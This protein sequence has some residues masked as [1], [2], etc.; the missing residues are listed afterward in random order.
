MKRT[1]FGVIAMAGVSMLGVAC[2]RPG[3]HAAGTGY[4]AGIPRQAF[5]LRGEPRWNAGSKLGFP[6]S[7]DPPEANPLTWNRAVALGDDKVCGH[8]AIGKRPSAKTP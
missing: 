2:E 8:L 7:A 1:I 3:P 4:G 6:D 5:V